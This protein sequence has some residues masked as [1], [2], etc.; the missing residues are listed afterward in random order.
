MQSQFDRQY[1]L[2]PRIDQYHRDAIRA[3]QLYVAGAGLL[4]RIFVATTKLNTSMRTM[5]AATHLYFGRPG[6]ISSGPNIDAV[7]LR[8]TA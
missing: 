6:T 4:N 7:D 3:E 5:L 1:L 2:K 8:V